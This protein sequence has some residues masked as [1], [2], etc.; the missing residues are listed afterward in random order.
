MTEVLVP[1]RYPLS[2]NSRATLDAAVTIAREESADLTVLHV[3]PYHEGRRVTRRELEQAVRGL[4]AELSDVRYVVS[5]GM[6]VEETILEEA[7]DRDAD[8]VVIGKAQVGRWKRLIRQLGGD[9]DIE[10]YLKDE[11]DCRLVIVDN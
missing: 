3:D 2:D 9:P 8:I 7:A 10:R 6:L 4:V 11:L 5:R 1:V